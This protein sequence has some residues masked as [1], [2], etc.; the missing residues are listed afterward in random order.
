MQRGHG[1]RANGMKRVRLTLPKVWMI[2]GS[3]RNSK[4]LSLHAVYSLCDE[5]AMLSYASEALTSSLREK[6]P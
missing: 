6:P 2:Q 4:C 5:A 3:T 1:T